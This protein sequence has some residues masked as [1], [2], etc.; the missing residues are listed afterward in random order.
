MKTKTINIDEKSF[1]LRELT[2]E[3]GM[4]LIANATGT[5]DIACLIRSATKINGEP[6]KE[7]EISLGT[8]MKLMPHVMEL[9]SF[10]GGDSG[11]G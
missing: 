6:A 8:A 9:N 4:P 5:I 10:A 1:E 7:G 3:E 11:N 2:M